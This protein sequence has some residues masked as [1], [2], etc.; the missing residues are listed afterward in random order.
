M[1]RQRGPEAERRRPWFVRDMSASRA[2]GAAS[3]PGHGGRRRAWVE[4]L[5]GRVRRQQLGPE[6]EPKVGE[7]AVRLL[8]RHLNLGDLVLEVDGCPRKQLCLSRL[9]DYDGPGAH[10]DLSSSLIGSALRDQA[11]QL[12]VPA[13]VLSSQ[14][15][16]SGLVQVCEADAGP[17]PKVLM[18]PDQRKKLS[19]LFEI[20][21]NLLAQSMFSRLSFCQE[22]WKVQNS[23]LLEAVWRLHV[24]NI[25]S[26]QELLESHADSQA[27]VAWLSRDLRL[28]CEQ[29]EAPCQHAD[30][31]R[32][33]LSDFVQ[34]LVLRGFQKNVDVRGTVEPEWMT[35]VAV[36]V[37]ER[38]LASALEALAA[39]IQEGSA[40]H[41]AV[42]CWFSVFSGHMYRSIISTESPKRFFCHTLTQILTHKP[43]LKVSD[44]VQMQREWS[45]ARTPP[46]LS[47]LYR[48]LFVIL[49]P[50]ELV[51]CLQEVLETREVNWQHVLSCVSTLVI[52]LPDAQQLVNGWVSRLLAHAFESCDLDSMVLAFLVARQ[53]AL[54][55]PAAFPSY[56]AWFQAAF[57]SARGFHS[58]SKKALVFLFKFLSDLVP[59]EAPRYLQVHVLHPPLV[60]SKYR[61]LLTDYVALART[62]LADLKVSIENMGLYE[63]LSSAGDV[64]E[65]HRQT[66]QDVEKAIMVFEHTGKIPAA[67]LEASIFRRSYYL[68]HFLP[69]L[70]TPRV[71]PRVPDSRAVL[72]ESLRRAEKI[73]PSLYSTYRQACSTV[74]EKPED[75]A[76]RREVEP[77][78]AEEPLGLL[79]TALR[80]LRA[81]VT[82]PPQHD[83]LSAQMAVISEQLRSALGLSEDDSDVEGAPVQLSVRAPE[84]RPWEQR[85][86]DLLLTSFCQNLMAASSV[87]PPDR[88]GPWAA[89]FVRTLCR[90]RL[91][92]ALL[93]RL[94]QLLRHQGPSLSASHVVGLA[95]LAVHLGESRSALPEVHV[96][97]PTPARGLPVPEL[98]DILLPCRTQESSA[99]CLKFCT[100]AISYSLCK[101]SSQS[102]D[103]LYSCLSPGLI[104]K[105][106]F[107][108]F[109]WFSEARD[110]PSWEDLASSPWRSLCLPSADWRRA[111]LCLWKQ[112]TS[113][114]LL[115]REGL[116]LTYRDWLQLELEIQPEVDSLSDTERRDFHQWAIH[117]HFLP[118]PSAT[119]G[120]DGDLEVACATLVDVLMDFCQSSRSYD[121]SENSDL[122]VGGCTGNRD[123]FS[124]LQEM[125]A[126]LEQGPAPLGRAAP[127]G[128]FL[129]GVFCRR[130]QALARGWDVASRLQRQR[131]LLMCKRILLG[132]PP[133]VLVGSPC[134]EQL[135]AP[136]CDDFFHLVNSELFVLKAVSL[137]A[138]RTACESSQVR[139]RRDSTWP[140][141]LGPWGLRHSWRARGWARSRTE[142]ALRGPWRCH[143]P[144][145][146][147]VVEPR[148]AARP[149]LHVPSSLAST[150]LQRNFSHDGALTHDITA[151]F[152]RG[153]LNACSRSRD[154]SLAADLTLTACQTQCP[155]LLTS[156]LLWW[157]HLEPELH[158][159][160]RRCSQS[161][162][163]TELRRLQE[164]QHFAASVLSPLAAPPAPGP[165]WLC[166]AALHFVIR[167]AGKESIRQELGQLDSQGEELLVFL[168]FFSLMGLLSSHLTPQATGSLKALDV[169][170]G[171]LGCLQRKRISWLPLFQLTEADA[172]LGCTLLRLAPDHQIRLLPVAFYSLLSYFDKDALL[173]EDAFLHV[174]VNMYLKLVG[175]FVAGETGAVWTPAHGGE[176]QAQ[177]GAGPG[178][179]PDGPGRPALVGL[180]PGQPL[181]AQRAA[182]GTLTAALPVFSPGR[183]RKPDNK[184]SSFS[185]AVNTSV[186]KKELLRRGRGNAQML[187]LLSV[188]KSPSLF[189]V[190][191]LNTFGKTS[192]RHP[193]LGI[194]PG[195]GCVFG[196][197]GAARAQHTGFLAAAGRE[198]GL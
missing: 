21:Q 162:L 129:F 66:S 164:A 159:R 45:F 152:F 48:R 59:F 51:D 131:E 133:S 157:P 57:G 91:L 93:S 193:A 113:R 9:I 155:L 185:A 83:A 74:R 78:C 163:P 2:R 27:V 76:S 147:Y 117:Q 10:T 196:G 85:V 104:K 89:H 191:V 8:R 166:A 6:G 75:A 82:D 19:S 35:Q 33:M 36:A 114:E 77:S 29:T 121:H 60:P 37:L 161:P 26:L 84:L 128:H 62:R 194:S 107:I 158:H 28:L 111:A 184:C 55:G 124:R 15:V 7:S 44:A 150:V 120:C 156:A 103:I 180:Q 140:A 190:R 56:A 3:D 186:P 138:L 42:S 90:R 98:F 122:V 108:V 183:P 92:P 115:Q 47:G 195:P 39:G 130:L 178:L 68:S 119:G 54:E 64:T 31:A 49:S 167:R 177:A 80:E 109:R 168:F 11:A 137:R 94:C 73:P 12:G 41:K 116:R 139:T 72:I 20:A 102:H 149:V 181:L 18:T 34:M 148:A 110:P 165:A 95:A 38:M 4:L 145:C 160:W 105:F 101:F 58:C 127:R 146:P 179:S 50:E 69:A 134:L 86:V 126:D 173:Q 97:P 171:V 197:R 24:Q 100:A 96:G 170:A 123:I 71:L 30:V 153:L 187:T 154:P 174:A 188:F 176:L 87:A 53:A 169:C 198:C 192:T 61:A 22:L 112:R 67:V 70:L 141:R 32:A 16:A 143:P 23:L 106:Q 13:A 5:A 189:T 79:T 88:Q 52:C 1:G 172:G 175:L 14:V 40:A 135:A 65:P 25:V 17:P 63:D 125:A 46:L 136:D 43:V 142:P 132:L 144:V 81:S 118:A 151:H 99:L 182:V